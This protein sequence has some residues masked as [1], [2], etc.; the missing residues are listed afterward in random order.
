M[1]TK[2]DISRLEHEITR[3]GGNM[4]QKGNYSAIV[5]S[6]TFQISKKTLKKMKILF[7]F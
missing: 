2:D 5:I 6:Y 3:M 7:A 1:A 4:K